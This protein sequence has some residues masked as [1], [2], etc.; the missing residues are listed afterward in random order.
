MQ[1]SRKVSQQRR[2]TIVDQDAIKAALG[3]IELTCITG[4]VL[5]LETTQY[6]ILGN[7]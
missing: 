6:D 2:Q 7:T 1:Y 5:S 4:S 3:N